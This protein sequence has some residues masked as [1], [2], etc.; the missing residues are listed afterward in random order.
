M[1]PPPT[2]RLSRIDGEFVVARLDPAAP[3]PPELFTADAPILSVTRTTSE[4]SIVC[5][6]TLA[7]KG[8]DTDGPWDAWY[9][10][11][12]IPFGLTGVVQSVVSPLSARAIPVFVVSTFD[13]DLILVPSTHAAVA[14]A[15]LREAGHEVR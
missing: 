6:P 5:L 12:P 15:A 10:E 14:A 1:I 11:G 7:P 4:L 8:A 3:L 2:V 9:I 13:S